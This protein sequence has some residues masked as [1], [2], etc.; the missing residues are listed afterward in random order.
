M[1]L[2]RGSRIAATCA[3]FALAMPL[4]ACS[5]DDL[6]PEL[7][8]PESEFVEN[9]PW[10]RL[11]DAPQPVS[12][13]GERSVET[14]NDRGRTIVESSQAEAERM[15][16]RAEAVR[17]RPVLTENLQATARRMRARADRVGEF[18]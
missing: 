3:V 1:T 10:P 14:Y 2:R 4:T 9:A 7:G 12:Q 17:A 11:V 16:A 6:F 5:S 8:L 13:T 15:R 18:E